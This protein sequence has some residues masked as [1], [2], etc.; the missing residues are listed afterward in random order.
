MDRKYVESSMISSI[1]YDS[2]SSTLEVEFKSDHQ[3]WQYLDV[4]EYVWYEFESAASI[5]KY[6]HENIKNKYSQNRI[7]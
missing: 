3:V 2:S 1:G 4:P 6:W 7:S 5:G